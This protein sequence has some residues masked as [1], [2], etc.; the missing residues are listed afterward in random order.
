M[1]DLVHVVEGTSSRSAPRAQSILNTLRYDQRRLFLTNSMAA[2]VIT[3]EG[4]PPKR[5]AASAH[6]F[7]LGYHMFHMSTLTIPSLCLVG[8]FLL[9]VFLHYDVRPSS[10]HRVAS[11]AVNIG[12]ERPF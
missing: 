7:H 9:G 8:C 11:L 1:F 10:L 5:G 3:D 2:D 4:S 12:P 6:E